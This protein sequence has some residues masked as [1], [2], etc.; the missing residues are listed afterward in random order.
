MSLVLF[1][2]LLI[3]SIIVGVTMEPTTLNVVLIS[4]S[5]LISVIGLVLHIIRANKQKRRV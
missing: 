3:N 4:L 1:A 5:A 2:L